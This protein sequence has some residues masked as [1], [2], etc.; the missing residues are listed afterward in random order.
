MPRASSRWARSHSWSISAR[1]GAPA[2]GGGGG[3]EVGLGHT[4]TAHVAGGEV[5]AVAAQVLGH[6]LEVLDDLESGAHRVGE[7]HAL[8]GGRAGDGENQ[9]ADRVG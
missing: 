7:A 8:G 9:A 1:R 3:R 4:E 5:D 2:G 6:V